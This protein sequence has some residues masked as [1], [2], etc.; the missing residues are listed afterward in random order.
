MRTDSM[1]KAP[2]FVLTSL[3]TLVL[4]ACGGGNDQ[5]S[6]AK[7]PSLLA[8]LTVNYVLDPLAPTSDLGGS[9]TPQPDY[10]GVS[11]YSGD[12]PRPGP[13]LLYAPPPRAPQL[14]NTGIWKARPIMIS[15][16]AA[17]RRG[18]YLYQDYLYDDRGARYAPDPNDPRVGKELLS[19]SA[20]TYT[21][22]SD[23]VYANNAADIVELRVK[24]QSGYTAFRLTM[25]SLIDPEKTAFTIA[26]GNSASPQ[27]FPFGA[28]VKA[29]AQFFL[30][31]HGTTAILMDAQTGAVISPAPTV[32]IDTLRRQFE[33]DIPTSAWN[34]GTS[35]VRIAAGAGLWDT[36]NGRYLL[37]ATTAS[38]AAP[39]GA[40][41]STAP[42]AFF[43][44]A[45]RFDEPVVGPSMPGTGTAN[46]REN[47]QASALAAGDI[48][49]FFANVDFAKLAANVND[50][51]LGQPQGTPN[52]GPINRIVASNVETKQGVD[53]NTVCETFPACKGE[54]RGQLQPYTLY[55]PAKAPPQGGYGL[56]L[57]LHSKAANHTQYFG[58]NNQTQLGER[59]QGH[60]V[61]T[62][63]ARGFDG[64]YVDDTA[65]DTF[66]VWAD[67]AR[68][69]RLNPA[70][71]NIT[72]Y[73]M[74]GHGTWK[75]STLYPDLFARAN[76][77]VG[78][79]ALGG[80]W[81][82]PAPPN[83][84]EDTNTYNLLASLR[85][86]PVM[87]W[88]ATADE[89]PAYTGVQKQ[90]QRIDELNYRYRL[91][92]YLTADHFT[93]YLH[94]NYAGSADFLGDSIV[95]RNPSHVSYVINPP[96][97]VATRGMVGN[98]AY[99]LSGMTVRDASI[100]PRGNIDAFSRAFGEGDPLASATQAGAGVSNGALGA[101]PYVSQFK[102]WGLPTLQPAADRLDLVARNVSSVSVNVKRAKL[103][104]NAVLV[105]DTD[106]PLTVNL[107][108]CNRSVKY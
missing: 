62:P 37:P 100:S 63:L 77:V 2:A 86:V 74:G 18:E 10:T 3:A 59:G 32:K 102:T 39:G 48:S 82:P 49:A 94:D 93:L 19:M 79:P 1:R 14:E 20:G 7:N 44:V 78:S 108:G 64:W 31:V 43:N 36:A 81:F 55:I 46:W 28:N 57:L 61:V 89:G 16:A 21:Y 6:Q 29:P 99:W 58:T 34:P 8:D 69:Y 35:V 70:M 66:E 72:G 107:E 27:A 98:H 50:D 75:F 41:A 92:T 73:S 85:N 101:L 105:V 42:A 84:P 54:Y 90:V 9:D 33:V 97:D 106:G 45:F 104:C 12:G 15:G 5:A 40:G 65:A 52:S 51:M 24:P 80:A 26:L 13:D 88:D 68:N 95:N 87:V 22:P 71:T 76:P 30:T 4:A 47:A 60:L 91:D 25:N 38:A 67:V 96:T 17:Y 11:L 56:T 23:P 53:F 83:G 103:T